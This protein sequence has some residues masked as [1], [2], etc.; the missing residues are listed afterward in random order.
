[1]SCIDPPL[2]KKPTRGFAWSCGSCS[3]A[4]ERRLEARSN[5]QIDGDNNEDEEQLDGDHHP[6][7]DTEELL[8]NLSSSK[9]ESMDSRPG[10]DQGLRSRSWPYRYL[11][12]HCK[13]E[14]ALDS[15]DRIYPRA[16]TRLGPKHQ[17][18]VLPWPGR[19]IEYI[20]STE[21]KKRYG[22]T[23]ILKKD[24][25]FSKEVNSSHESDR[26]SREVRPAWVVDQPQGFIFRG[27]DLSAD[28]PDATTRLIFDGNSDEVPD[29]PVQGVCSSPS[30]K[31]DAMD[32]FLDR[33]RQ[34]A[35]VMN[36][37]QCSTDFT[38]K[39]LELLQHHRFDVELALQALRSVD[40]NL[41]LQIP[42]FN[43]EQLSAFEEGVLRYGSELQ[44]VTKHVNGSISS[45]LRV[46]HS[47]VV[48][49]YY[50]WKKTPAGREIWGNH[51][52]RKGKK[53]G[54]KA[55]E[56]TAKLI[57]DLADDLD[58][59]A[60]DNDK[61]AI[62]RCKFQCRFCHVR[63][64]RLWRRAPGFALSSQTIPVRPTGS[65]PKEKDQNLVSALCLRCASLWRR[66][67]IHYED[68][69]EVAKRVSQAGGRAARRRVDEELLQELMAAN[70]AVGMIPS[71]LTLDA[72]DAAGL[73]VPEITHEV[74]EEASASIKKPKRLRSGL[75][76]S[77]SA[78]T[79]ESEAVPAP[80]V[81]K[82]PEKPPSQPLVIE[83]PKPKSMP[84]AVCQ[85]PAT[86][87][88]PTVVCKDCRMTV[89]DTCYGVARERAFSKWVC[90]TC[91]NDRNLQTTTVSTLTLTAVMHH[92]KSCRSRSTSAFSA[93]WTLGYMISWCLRGPV[94]RRRPK[95][96]GNVSDWRSR[97]PS[98]L[99]LFTSRSRSTPTSQSCQGKH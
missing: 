63:Q 99:L 88:S 11:G 16:G 52:G 92:P 77:N 80:S 39:A 43:S 49:F 73:V 25:R 85:Y 50:V 90:D 14:D 1:M 41:D 17:A 51:A 67:G 27:F 13:V 3:R 78:A 46:S 97:R 35:A 38:T 81:K 6:Q 53:E 32:R 60:Y 62:R 8:Q 64:S 86:T 94:R 4:Q 30:A 21:S 10:A 93:P 5:P 84:C 89:H 45:D 66:Y 61:A 20:R 42:N 83:F 26:S 22:K 69:D 34:I 82:K 72:A 36:L 9:H 48:R 95:E 55:E 98:S 75:I 68:I 40:V 71:Q 28:D 31:T 96:I 54:R 33:A 24:Q 18:V 65:P 37:H 19:P 57:D 56:T 74:V 15:D 2:L 70:A 87:A 29:T 59:S 47:S 23:N 58:D 76:A 79:S 12:I 7:L 44:S 91:M